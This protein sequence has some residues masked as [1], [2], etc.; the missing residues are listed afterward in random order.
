[1]KKLFIILFFCLLS[2]CGLLDD[3]HQC[4]GLSPQYEEKLLK[5]YE[6]ELMSYEELMYKINDAV[7]CKREVCDGNDYC[8]KHR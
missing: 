1:M 3:C 5:Y 7:N 6:W 2:G 8:T 4:K